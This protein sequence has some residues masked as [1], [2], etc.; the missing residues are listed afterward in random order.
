M[1]FWWDTT[2]SSNNNKIVCL[3]LFSVQNLYPSSFYY[4]FPFISLKTYLL[5]IVSFG[6]NAMVFLN[7]IIENAY[8]AVICYV[9]KR[10]KSDR[11]P[12]KVNFNV[13]I[14]S[15]R[16][17]YVI[18]IVTLQYRSNSVNILETLSG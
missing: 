11:R 5:L 8:P 14:L 10:T 9:R 1:T 4:P 2:E 18:D 15:Y 16:S 17:I 7:L 3:K 6:D 13:F 12:T